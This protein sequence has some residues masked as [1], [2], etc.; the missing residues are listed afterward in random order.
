MEQLLQCPICDNKQLNNYHKIKDYFLTQEDF[1]IVRCE[2]CGF[3]FL[4]PRPDKLEIAPYYKAEA[5]ISHSDTK[6][7]MI[8]KIYQVV[9]NLN[10]RKKYKLINKY[11]KLGKIL[12]IGC[13]TGDVLAYFSK[14][15]W[16][17][18]G[19]EPDVDARKVAQEKNLLHLHNEQDF[20]G[21]PDSS[22]DVITMWHVMEHVHN[23]EERMKTVRRLIKTD[24]VFIFSVPIN[25]SW[26]AKHYGRF[27]A[28]W[29]VPRHLYH[30]SQKTAQMLIEKHHFKILEIVPMKYDA[31]YISL[32]SEKYKGGRCSFFKAFWAG[33]RSN[34]KAKKH[35]NNYSSLIF[36]VSPH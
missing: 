6:K 11:K 4:N 17:V 24:G 19:V 27:W 30:F 12:D 36:V 32:L 2:Q 34:C 21:F 16:Q 22:F 20:S 5:Y 1:T 7:G 35:N 8:A 9:R 33:M 31:Y 13:G 29:D 23:L 25:E 28:A 10:I 26:D 15:S 3:L 18:E 14:K